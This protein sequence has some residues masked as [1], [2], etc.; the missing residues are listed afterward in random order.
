MDRLKSWND[1][2]RHFHRENLIPRGD[3]DGGRRHA[4]LAN[5]R[6][7]GAAI[8]FG[9]SKGQASVAE[10]KPQA[11]RKGRLDLTTRTG[12]LRARSRLG[13]RRICLAVPLWKMLPHH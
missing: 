6:A 10:L 2:E 11:G 13:E 8:T 9:Q 1:L 12:R 4:Q 5:R 7:S 3:A